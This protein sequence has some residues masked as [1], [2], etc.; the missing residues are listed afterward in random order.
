MSNHEANQRIHALG[1]AQKEVVDPLFMTPL[2]FL[3][4]R[5]D[6]IGI[7]P[8]IH[9]G[10]VRRIMISAVLFGPS[11]LLDTLHMVP[12]SFVFLSLFRLRVCLML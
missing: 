10:S 1:K 3:L 2:G 8:L 9:Y 11:S 4:G 7:R 6:L 5:S 12:F